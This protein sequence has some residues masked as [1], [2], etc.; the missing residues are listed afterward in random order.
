MEIKIMNYSDAVIETFGELVKIAEKK[1]GVILKDATAR[2]VIRKIEATNSSELLHLFE[3]AKYGNAV[4][5][6]NDFSKAYQAFT[7][8]VEEIA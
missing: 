4:L 1:K 3:A 7:G 2:E 8:I 6:R 5:T